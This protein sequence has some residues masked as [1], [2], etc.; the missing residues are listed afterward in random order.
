MPVLYPHGPVQIGRGNAV[1]DIFLN[2]NAC[3]VECEHRSGHQFGYGL[4]SIGDLFRRSPLGLAFVT[5]SGFGLFYIF[6]GQE[7]LA[8]LSLD[9][10]IQ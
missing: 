5:P 2:A 9:G 7:T 3:R 4:S 1:T 8:S 10:A 6:N